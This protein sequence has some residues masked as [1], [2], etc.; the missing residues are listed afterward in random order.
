M[1]DASGPDFETVAWVYSQSELA[2]LLALLAHEDI[3]VVPIGRHNAAADYAMTLALGG[4][5]IRVHAEEAEEARALLAGIDSTPF[6]R[7]IFSDNRW[8]D[9]LIILILFC[10]GCFAPPARVPA[11]FVAPRAAA[12]RSTA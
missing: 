2:V 1:S 11:Q 8:L 7:G 4:I 5:E 10:A 6:R 12:A 3:L 9:G